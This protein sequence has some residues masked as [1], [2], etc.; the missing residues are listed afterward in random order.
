[1]ELCFANTS[2]RPSPPAP[3]PRAGEGGG[4]AGRRREELGEGLL[5]SRRGLTVGFDADGDLDVLAEDRAGVH[6]TVPDDAVVLAVEGEGGLETSL[7][8]LRGLDRA[9]EVD[10][11]GDPLG[12]AVHGQVAGD[13]EGVLV[14]RL[15]LGAGEGEGGEL[16]DVEEVRGA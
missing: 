2:M 10:G 15:D 16:L 8:G 1:M 5:R 4:L 12:D 11:D 3:L 7:L 14:L 6:H 9:Q 13:L